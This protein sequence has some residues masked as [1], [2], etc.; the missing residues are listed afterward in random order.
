VLQPIRQTSENRIKWTVRLISL[1]IVVTFWQWW[2]A[3]PGVI[4]VSPPTKVI[5]QLVQ[6]IT[7]GQLLTAA[8]GTLVELVFGYLLAA[9]IGTGLGIWLG[10]SDFAYNTLEPIVNA[11]Y[12]APM[13]ALLPII[14]IYLGFDLNARIFVVFLWSVVVV[15]INT[16]IGIRTTTPYL[17]DM[18]HSF[19]APPRKILTAII[20]PSALPNILTG[21]RLGLGQAI[22]AAI[23]AEFLLSMSNMGRYIFYA[24]S[25]FNIA[26]VFAGIVFIT[27]FGVLIMRLFEGIERYILRRFALA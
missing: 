14:G 19:N 6:G 18:A 2:G 22:R 24:Q 10:L 25:M 16:T 23:T 15:I 12:M 9:F 8:S 11:L 5:P 7:S 1:A 4:A 27:G 3:Q 26:G 21:L 17:I 13:I 20:L